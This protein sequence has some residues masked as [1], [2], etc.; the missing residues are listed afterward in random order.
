MSIE[1]YCALLLSND[2]YA[3]HPKETQWAKTA[4]G[5][6]CCHHEVDHL[7]DP[8]LLKLITARTTHL[9]GQFKLRAQVVIASMYGFETGADHIA[10]ENNHTLFLQL[11]KDLSFI[12]YAHGQTL[13]EHTGIYMMPAI[14]QVI[15]DM[16]FKNKGDDGVCW[17][18]Y[19]NSFP[20]VGFAL[21]IT[22]IECAINE[23]ESGARGMIVFKEHKY[24]AVFRS[25]LASLEE[26]KT[27]TVSINLL[28]RIQ[29]QVYDTG[30]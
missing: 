20:V 8:A 5:Q 26:F 27:V 15:N 11:K 30:W 14:Q 29:Q 18:K 19:Y 7:H 25:H 21:A 6:A 28:A 2:L 16:L 13:D 3:P 22:A 12:C 9:R 23:W 4:W 24:S 10:I 1:I 17:D